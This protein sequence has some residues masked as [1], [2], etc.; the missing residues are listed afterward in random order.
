MQLERL[1]LDRFR[2][3]T[4]THWEPA[5]GINLVIGGNGAG[6]TTLLEATHLLANGRSF[7]G[8]VRDGLVQHG[9][10]DLEVFAQWRE[11]PARL[12]RA[13]LRHSGRDWQAR[14]D[15][16]TVASLAELCTALAVLTFEPGSHALVAGSSDG[17]RRFVDWAL[18]HV[19]P[20][21][22]PLWRRYTRAM[23]QRN[24]LLKARPRPADLD[25]WDLEIAL[26]G[27]PMTRMRSLYLEQLAPLL[28][29]TTAAF[30]P[31]VGPFRLE[32]LPGWR[33]DRQSLAT[34][35]AEARERDLVVGHGTVG[36]HRADWRV[37]FERLPSW[38]AL[39]RGQ[40]KLVALACILA[41]GQSYADRRGEW[42]I[43]AFDDLG[44]ELDPDHQARVLDD[45]GR[46][47]AQ[48]LITGTAPLPPHRQDSGA[49]FHVEHGSIQR[50]I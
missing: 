16:Q 11:G 35:L 46:C 6:K 50:R 10:T 12:R 44:S 3:F 15:G 25:P 47:G 13:G 21:F 1:T 17:R 43:L 8:R 30:L 32:F 18:F 14:L 7:R 29:N 26:A 4:S 38:T 39:S 19:E 40:E 48:T 49:V 45:V 42:P 24:A 37:V 9:R 34:A 23:K 22:M 20:E 5:T 2:G 27:E 31:E 36:P 28:A 41:V 33:R